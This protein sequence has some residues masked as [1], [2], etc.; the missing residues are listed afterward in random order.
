MAGRG[1]G[2]PPVRRPGGGLTGS[3]SSLRPTL[4]RQF[5]RLCLTAAEKTKA[6]CA[7]FSGTDETGYKYALHRPGGGHGR[8]CPGR[9]A[10]APCRG[11]GRDGLAQG[12]VTASEA[13]IRAFFAE[14][15]KERDKWTSGSWRRILKRVREDHTWARRSRCGSSSR[16]PGGRHGAAGRSPGVGKTTLVKTSPWLWAAPSAASQYCAGPVPSGHSGHAHLQPEN[17]GF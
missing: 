6:R 7:V 17:R 2:K 3:S 5:R 1:A 11:G 13:E 12:S 4:S 15:F 10:A 9:N 8:P 16:H 14:K